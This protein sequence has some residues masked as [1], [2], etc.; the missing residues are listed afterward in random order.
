MTPNPKPSVLDLAAIAERLVKTVV[1]AAEA[2]HRFVETEI[3]PAA[4]DEQREA[5]D[6]LRRKY[7][8]VRASGN[9]VITPMPTQPACGAVVVMRRVEGT[10]AET[11]FCMRTDGPCPYGPYVDI[12]GTDG[13]GRC[14]ETGL[15]GG[16]LPTGF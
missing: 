8:D 12:H 11:V 9:T 14:A 16:P 10:A 6:E 5:E 4:R 7:S 13:A 1:E 2:V 15:T 3:I